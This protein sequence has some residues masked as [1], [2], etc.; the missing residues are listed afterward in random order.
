VAARSSSGSASFRLRE[1]YTVSKLFLASAIVS[2]FG[3]CL[4][5]G[6][7]G[8]AV[9]FL[10]LSKKF[11]EDKLKNFALMSLAEEI[12]RHPTIDC[13]VWLLVATLM[14]MYNEKEQARQGKTTKCTV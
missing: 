1:G 3:G 5:N 2:V 7:P 10:P 4:W 6:S 11:I 12:V 14:Y 9:C 8:G 13:V